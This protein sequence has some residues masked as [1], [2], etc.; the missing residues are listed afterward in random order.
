MPARGNLRSDSDGDQWRARCDCGWEGDRR[1]SV[2]DANF[3]ALGHANFVL[4]VAR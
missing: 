2:D 3:E 1:V 4:V